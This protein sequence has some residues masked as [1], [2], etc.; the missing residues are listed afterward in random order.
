[1][2]LEVIAATA[3]DVIQAN[4]GG[5]DRI[6]LVSALRE[7]GLTPSP[8]LIDAAVELSGIPVH[9]LIRPHSR[10]F[11]YDS[12]DLAVMRRDIEYARQAG[13]AGVVLGALTP[14]RR[15]D[16]QALRRL[17]EWAE[18][19]HVTFHRAF[20]KARD[21]DEALSGLLAYP[22]IN[23][24]LTSGG[25]PSALE[26]A[27][28][29]ARLQ[30]RTRGTAIRVLAGAGLTVNH[31]SDFVRRTGVE[32]VHLGRGV[33]IDGSVDLPIDA[34]LVRQAKRFLKEK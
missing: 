27:D 26:A 30:E 5:A 4:R 32:E 15:V 17:L 11:V 19:M 25:A 6:E 23:R 12:H 34:E 24:V 16:E 9:V 14:D 29:I 8:G 13:A 31:I 7:G 2:I 33:R 22:Q 28:T 1:M 10:S 21:L 3:D 18:G 20:D